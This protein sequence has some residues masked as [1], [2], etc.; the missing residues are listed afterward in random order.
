MQVRSL[1]ALLVCFT[2]CKKKKSANTNEAREA[3]L[4]AERAE[5]VFALL[6]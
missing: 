6:Y 4:L 5:L 1:L 2:R 3:Q